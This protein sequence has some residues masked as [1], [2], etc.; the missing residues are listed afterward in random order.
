MNESVIDIGMYVTYGLLAI[1]AVSAIIFS[2]I[3]MVSDFRKAIPTLIGIGVLVLIVL[4]SYSIGTSETYENAGPAV[5]QWVGGGIRATMILI[6][7]GLLSAV[8]TE[9]Y[10]Y[11]R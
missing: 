4:F 1:A 10:K 7:L 2:L 6:G 3:H 11:F 5:S 9:V 8:F